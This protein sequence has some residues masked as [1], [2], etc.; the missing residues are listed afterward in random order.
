MGRAALVSRRSSA[1][2]SSARVRA[3]ARSA[4]ITAKAFSSRCLRLR[5]V[6]VPSWDVGVHGEVIAAEPFHRHDLAL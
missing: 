6:C 2:V 3:I 1:R 4:T 5:N